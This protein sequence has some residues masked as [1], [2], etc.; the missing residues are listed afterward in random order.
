MRQTDREVSGLLLR[1]AL[2]GVGPAL[3]FLPTPL[4]LLAPVATAITT[5][6]L[7]RVVCRHR[8]PRV[9]GGQLVWLG[10]TLPASGPARVEPT[11]THDST[12][13]FQSGGEAGWCKRVTH[14]IALELRDALNAGTDLVPLPRLGPWFW[15]VQ[16]VLPLVGFALWA[17]LDPKLVAPVLPLTAMIG[18]WWGFPDTDTPPTWTKSPGGHELTAR[19]RESPLTARLRGGRSGPAF[20]AMRSGLLLWPPSL[21]VL[22][23]VNARWEVWGLW[24]MVVFA[25]LLLGVVAVVRTWMGSTGTLVASSD[26]ETDELWG[27]ALSQHDRVGPVAE[28]ELERAIGVV[29]AR[30]EWVF[31]VFGLVTSGGVVAATLPLPLFVH[32][33]VA[34]GSVLVMQL[35]VRPLDGEACLIVGGRVALLG[36]GDT[37]SRFAMEDA[38]FRPFRRYVEL[39]LRDGRTFRLYTSAPDALAHTLVSLRRPVIAPSDADL[40]GA[41][42][43]ERLRA[44]SSA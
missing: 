40:E 10:Q 15:A 38:T 13:H 21:V 19:S 6:L 24:P 43:L 27:K 42:Q 39:S 20:Q 12:L 11:G 35:V 17:G 5:Q 18:G 32:G 23:V 41:R 31:V 34:L 30:P 7:L 36:L 37:W 25:G 29:W 28:I 3:A 1:G 26:V 14:G 2:L 16:G 4:A 22:G 9:V 44:R 33:L 8:W